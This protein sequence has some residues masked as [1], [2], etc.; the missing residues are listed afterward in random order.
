MQN[1]TDN[2]L[3]KEDEEKMGEKQRQLKHLSK[4]LKD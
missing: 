4:F 1:Y 2:A 3:G